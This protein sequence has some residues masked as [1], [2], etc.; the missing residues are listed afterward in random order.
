METNRPGRSTTSGS[1]SSSAARSAT[2][3]RRPARRILRNPTTPGS[4]RS[5]G[6]RWTCCRR[7]SCPWGTPNCGKGQPGQVGH[8]GHPA[9]PA[10]FQQ[11][12]CRGA[13]VDERHARRAGPRSRAWRRSRSAE[14][15]V[16]VDRH[17]L[18]LTRFANSVIPQ[19]V[20][21][22][23]VNRGTRVHLDGRTA[24]ASTT[25]SGED[26]L[27]ALVAAP[28]DAVRVA[29]LDPGWPGLAPPAD[30]PPVPRS[31]RRRPR[32]HRR[33]APRSCERSSTPRWAGARRYCPPTTGRG[34]SPTQLG[35]SRETNADVAVAGIARRDGC[36]GGRGRPRRGS[37]TSTVPRFAPGRRR[38]RT[39]RSTPSSP[40][41]SPPGSCWRP[42]RS[43]T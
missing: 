19:N 38:R 11:R 3:S 13:G 16:A 25:V 41:P 39:P 2:R 20:G 4:A 22:D 31:T 28:L 23:V 30:A 12:A 6:A 43:P 40:P 35:K 32:R 37:P 17:R 5:S 9:A 27:A 10:R 15:E 29:P 34:R 8:T 42:P 1:T 21:E 14:V 33:I 18:A 24:S 36:D 26:G 7:R